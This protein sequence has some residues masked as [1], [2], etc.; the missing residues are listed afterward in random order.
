MNDPTQL[1]IERVLGEPK[2]LESTEDRYLL[3]REIVALR[4]VVITARN[5][6]EARKVDGK[7]AQHE[8]DQHEA[9]FHADAN[10]IMPADR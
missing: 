4:E 5:A 9:K 2:F 3:A 10:E 7:K 8:A 1:E 6:I